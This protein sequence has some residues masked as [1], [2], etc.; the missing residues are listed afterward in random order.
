MRGFDR[1]DQ[2]ADLTF[3]VDVPEI[4][5]SIDESRRPTD[6]AWR[7]RFDAATGIVTPFRSGDSNARRLDR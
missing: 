5:Q 6:T 7:H 1:H 4:R 3:L 2:R